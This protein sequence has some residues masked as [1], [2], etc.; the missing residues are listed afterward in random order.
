MSTDNTSQPSENEST[1]TPQRETEQREGQD[2]GAITAGA[3][4]GTDTSREGTRDDKRSG[5][6]TEPPHKGMKGPDSTIRKE[7]GQTGLSPFATT[8]HGDADDKDS[9]DLE[10]VPSGAS[11][12]FR[13]KFAEVI[14]SFKAGSLR[15]AKNQIVRNADEART[16]ARDLAAKHDAKQDAKQDESRHR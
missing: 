15:D 10:G 5:R 13:D 11:R 14:N 12:R 16:M 1:K 8:R 6:E 4:R 9:A 3:N 7:T 2:S